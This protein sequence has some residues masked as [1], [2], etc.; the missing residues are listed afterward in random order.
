MFF[1]GKKHRS[2][3]RWWQHLLRAGAYLSLLAVGLYISLPWLLPTEMLRNRVAESLTS[4]LGAAVSIDKLSI[5]W[6]RGVEVHGITID[7]PESFGG[8]PMITIQSLQTDLAPL[9]YLLGR[10][11]AWIQLQSPQVFAVFNDASQLNL[12]SLAKLQGDVPERIRVQSGSAT[13]IAAGQS[14]PLRLDITNLDL[15][16][17]PDGQLD[18]MAMSA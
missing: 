13:V 11:L 1:R 6:A 8:G 12:T 14:Q 4:Q 15:L 7:S 3:R 16:N 9:R 5:S 2:T 10:R 18:S 17:R